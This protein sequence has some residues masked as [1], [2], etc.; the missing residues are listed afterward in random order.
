M[1]ASLSDSMKLV[2][3]EASVYACGREIS[4]QAAAWSLVDI[5]KHCS[6]AGLSWVAA[7]VIVESFPVGWRDG[8]EQCESDQ[9]ASIWN[10]NS[11]FAL[12]LD[13]R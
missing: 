8:E 9:P 5:G 2:F 3:N 7:P 6:V 11:V 10:I 12:G 1:V 13:G 4:N